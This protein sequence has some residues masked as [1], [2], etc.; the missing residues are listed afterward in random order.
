[1]SEFVTE[2]GAGVHRIEGALMTLAAAQSVVAATVTDPV[3]RTEL[4]AAIATVAQVAAEVV[5]MHVASLRLVRSR[6]R[7]GGD[8]LTYGVG[9]RS[10]VRECVA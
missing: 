9:V 7:E 6:S 3:A 5:D 1:M 8:A 10:F 2:A 4:M